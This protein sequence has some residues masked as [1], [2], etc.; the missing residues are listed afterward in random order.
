M[1]TE[2]AKV[3]ENED[4]IYTIENGILYSDFK[5]PLKMDLDRVKS[6]IKLRHDISEGEK[7]LWCCSFQDLKGFTKEGR[8]YAEIHGQ[9][10]LHATAVIVNSSVLKYIANLWNKLK[11]PHVPMMVFTSKVEAENWL[12]NINN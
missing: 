3:V 5:K 10:Y 4:I 2:Q 9:D 8:D 11:K 12:R 6:M 1:E 7:Q